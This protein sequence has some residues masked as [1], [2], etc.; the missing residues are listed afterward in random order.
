MDGKCAGSALA[1]PGR[2]AATPHT[3]HRWAGSSGSP[4]R[5]P[6]PGQVAPQA[7]LVSTNPQ[8]K[9]TDLSP[10]APG[11]KEPSKRPPLLSFQLQ[12]THI[13][14][15]ASRINFIIVFSK[16]I[17]QHVVLY[18]YAFCKCNTKNE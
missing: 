11:L 16:T 9:N 14:H 4:G 3:V 7:V 13:H 1:C 10:A 8:R 18:P 17:L 15:S 5:A 12:S 2:A 6:S